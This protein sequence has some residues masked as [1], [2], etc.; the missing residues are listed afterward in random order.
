MRKQKPPGQRPSRDTLPDAKGPEITGPRQSLSSGRPGSGPTIQSAPTLRAPRPAT[1]RKTMLMGMHILTEPPA[2]A[3]ALQKVDEESAEKTADRPGTRVGESETGYYQLG[4]KLGEGGM[5]AVYKATMIR[6]N[7]EGKNVMERPV[8][9]KVIKF[10]ETLEGLPDATKESM[11]KKMYDR[12]IT[13]VQVIAKLNHPGIIRIIDFGEGFVGKDGK[14]TNDPYY[15]MEHL[16]GVELEY[17]IVKVGPVTWE[18][19]RN[20]MIQTCKALEAAHS[21]E[22]NG[23]KHP[24]IHRDIKPAN[25]FVITDPD[26]E[27]RVKV[28]DFGLAKIIEPTVK[29]PTH[30]GEGAMGTPEYMAPE[31]ARGMTMDNRTDIYSIGAVMYHMLTGRVPIYFE[32]VDKL[33]EFFHKLFEETPI[34]LR[35]A[36]PEFDIPEDVEGMVMRCLEKDPAKRYQSVRELRQALTRA[37]I[38]TM[39]LAGPQSG[40]MWPASESF[41]PI[42]LK[43]EMGELPK[44][45]MKEGEVI[46]ALARRRRKIIGLAAGSLGLLITAGIV[47]GVLLKSGP[48]KRERKREPAVAAQMS[49]MAEPIHRDAGTV[50]A[51]AP[52][53]D[54]GVPKKRTVTF[55]TNL[56]GVKVYSGKKLLC[57]TAADGACSITLQKGQALKATFRRKGYKKKT[58]TVFKDTSGSVSVTLE[59]KSKRRRRRR[60]KGPK[61]KTEG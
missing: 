13:E 47:A 44:T 37:G 43:H 56:K 50:M 19:T 1:P 4:E 54:V 49:P 3:T 52:R 10:D 35:K 9:I 41:P 2:G 33:V 31:Q 57:T 18:R 12:F 28:L 8:A 32:G 5:G 45:T 7:R 40:E 27:Q 20:L 53:I 22:E 36:A 58:K 26:G 51:A 55:R 29:D 48:E 25:I 16:K 39:G 23:V 14:K 17:I 42:P 21:H 24:I 59:R 15:V 38:N 46:S 11:R 30:G 60:R 61:I 34:P 6:K